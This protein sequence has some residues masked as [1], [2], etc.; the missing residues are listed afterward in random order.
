[1]SEEPR[2]KKGDRVRVLPLQ[3]TE[4][5]GKYNI[6]AGEIHVVTEATKGGRGVHLK[7]MGTTAYGDWRFE[8]VEAKP[9]RKKKKKE[10]TPKP[11]RNRYVR[12]KRDG[13]YLYSFGAPGSLM[14]TKSHINNY[15][16][17]F[18]ERLKSAR[19]FVVK[20][21]P[22][23]WN[24]HEWA[25]EEWE[26]EDGER[27]F[28]GGIHGGLGKFIRVIGATRRGVRVGEETEEETA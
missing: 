10:K 20:N 15:G 18:E 21:H 23:T 14:R 28:D 7:G 16:E 12:V 9:S 19:E 24:H 27:P 26:N 4:N 13:M 17:T 11:E 8:L 5:L 2:F 22:H 25:A 3:G 1:M 6:R